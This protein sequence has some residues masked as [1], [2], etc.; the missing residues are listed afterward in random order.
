M[1]RLGDPCDRAFECDSDLCVD[2]TVNNVRHAV[3]AQPCCRESDCPLGFGCLFLRGVKLCLPARIYPAGFTFDR[4]ANQSCGGN[5]CQSGLCD[6]GADRCLGG[7]CINADCPGG[8]CQW[9][10]TGS[11]PRAICDPVPLGFGRTGDAC[12]GEL[13]CASRV[14]VGAAAP[15][16]CAD[17]CCTHAQCPDGTGCGRIG[18]FGVGGQIEGVITACVPQARGP[19]PDGAACVDDAECAGGDCIEG[20][21]TRPCCADVDCGAGRRC[22]PRPTREGIFARVC[23]VPDP[24]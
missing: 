4:Q 24:P 17:P 18:A 7:C 9:T 21:C 8:L 15:G 12:F 3:C 13:D 5:G 2:V 23:A 19:A 14:C 11:G 1:G 16:V 10:P 6:V 20:T 22:L